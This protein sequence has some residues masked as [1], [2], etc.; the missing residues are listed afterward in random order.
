MAAAV[1][2]PLAFLQQQHQQQRWVAVVP[3]ASESDSCSGC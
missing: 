3:A 2:R 1:R